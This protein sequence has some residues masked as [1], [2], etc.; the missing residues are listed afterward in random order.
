MQPQPPGEVAGLGTARQF[1]AGMSA[2]YTGQS[3]HTGQF[4]ATLREQGVDGAV[5]DAAEAAQQASD[6]AAAAWARADQVLTTHGQVGEAYA[7]NPGAGSKEF[8]MDEQATAGTPTAS[9]QQPTEPAQPPLP[10]PLRLAGR[11]QLDPGEQFAGSGSAKDDEGMMMLAAAVDTPDGRQVHIGVPIFDEDRKNWRGAHAPEHDVEVDEEDDG[12]EYHVDTGSANTV[13][14]DAADAARLPELAADVVARAAAVDKEYQGLVK[15]SDRLH[16]DR[17]ALEAKRFGSEEQGQ[18]KMDADAKVLHDEEFQRHRRRD[19]EAAVDR[20]PS[21]DRSRYDE[22]QRQVD[23][24]GTDAWEP[25]KDAEA[26]AVCG[27][28]VAEFEELRDLSRI[29]WRQRSETQAARHDELKFGDGSDCLHPTLPPLLA[30]QAAIVCGLTLEEFREMEAL[31]RIPKPHRSAYYNRNR[32]VRTPDEQ[33]RLDELDA[34]PGG[35][36]GTTDRQTYKLRGSYVSRQ[37]THHSAKFDTAE[38]REERASIDATARPLEP[39]EAAELERIT[40][41]LNA[42]NAR[43]DELGGFVSATAEIPARNGGA[44]VIEA[45]QKDECGGVSYNV[46]RR[47]ADADEEWTPGA[48]GEPFAPTAAG[49]RK[50]AALARKMAGS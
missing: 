22:L 49:L 19:M 24:A 4:V 16:A 40:A 1:A 30:E 31:E 17:A 26:A 43:M 44:L 50:A 5:V 8:V 46:A 29:P 2:A 7:A 41:D 33:A 45:V 34:A 20:L 37:R 23:A 15:D 25:G 14:L 11:F 27:L 3:E 12:E 9:A 21:E 28:T 47:P 36:R 39:G 13:V 6:A 38:A 18:R 48:D 10:D 42:V 32:R 35:A